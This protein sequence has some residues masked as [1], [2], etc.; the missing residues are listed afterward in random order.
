MSSWHSKQHKNVSKSV[1]NSLEPRPYDDVVT[2]VKA[3]ALKMNGLPDSIIIGIINHKTFPCY[4]CLLWVLLLL[5]F[6]TVS[7]W[8]SGKKMPNG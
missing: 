4:G 3:I 7:Q 5:L 2:A 6:F 8:I 1:E